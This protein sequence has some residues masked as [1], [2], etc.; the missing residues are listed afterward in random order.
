M[1]LSVEASELVELFQ[2]VSEAQME[3][4]FDEKFKRQVGHELSD[5]LVYL[6]RLTHVLELDLPVLLDE[7]I[8][9]NEQKYPADQVRG[10]A[11]KYTEY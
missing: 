7:K 3:Q 11:K 10:S 2:W 5:I 9:L 4:G 6:L 8:V 1:A